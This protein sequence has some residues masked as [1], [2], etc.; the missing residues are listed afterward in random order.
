MLFVIPKYA[1][2]RA[3]ETMRNWNAFF[4]ILQSEILFSKKKKYERTENVQLKQH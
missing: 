4:N 1:V 2:V 3:L